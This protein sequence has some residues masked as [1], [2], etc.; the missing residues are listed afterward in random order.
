MRH[1][2][3]WPGHQ[4]VAG[5]NVVENFRAWVA[6]T[7]NH[8]FDVTGLWRDEYVDCCC[9]ALGIEAPPTDHSLLQSY[10]EDEMIAN[11]EM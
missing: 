10:S 3:K 4:K 5:Y 8:F 2:L 11:R 7:T 1:W 9:T 6:Q